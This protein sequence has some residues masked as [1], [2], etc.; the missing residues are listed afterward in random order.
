[1]SFAA[2]PG[3]RLAFWP[4]WILWLCIACA[5]AAFAVNAGERAPAL[6]LPVLSLPLVTGERSFGLNRLHGLSD[7]QG[8]VVYLDFW[9]TYCKP[10]RESLP[11]LSA[12]QDRVLQSGVVIYSVNLD[13]DPRRATA[14]LADHPV[15]FAVVSDPSTVAA[16]D[17][18]LSSLPTAYFIGRDGRVADVHRGFVRGDIEAIEQRLMVLAES[19]LTETL[20]ETEEE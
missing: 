6:L 13:P 11:L 2:T 17:Y 7:L 19:D 5:P 15:S 18:G 16:A 3:R 12:L 20:A 14:F 9:D 4:C 8:K 10:C 1:M